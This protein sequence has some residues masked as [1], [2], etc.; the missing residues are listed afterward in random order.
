MFLW[1]L[2]SDCL[3]KLRCLCVHYH[4]NCFFIQ[5][6]NFFFF[7][8]HHFIHLI[9][10][11]RSRCRELERGRRGQNPAG[12]PVQIKTYGRTGVLWTQ[13]GPFTLF[14]SPSFIC[15]F[16]LPLLFIHL[17]FL[18]FSVHS[19]PLFPISSAILLF[20]FS[21]VLSCPPFLDFPIVLAVP[22]CFSLIVPPFYSLVSCTI[23]ITPMMYS[24]IT[25]ERDNLNEFF[26][27]IIICYL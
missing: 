8:P 13:T 25:K 2:Y 9:V 17:V 14:G 7:P 10:Y 16:S 18:F 20:L 4:L 11:H 26:Y 15:D 27:F 6:E 21:L 22:F 1:R 23:M 12:D 5:W 24:T 19:L 3:R